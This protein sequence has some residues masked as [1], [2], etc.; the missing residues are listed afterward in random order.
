MLKLIKMAT[1]PLSSKRKKSKSK[2]K[3]PIK[4]DRIIL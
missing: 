4:G 1:D 2:G 3:P